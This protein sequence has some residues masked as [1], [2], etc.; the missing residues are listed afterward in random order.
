[1]AG[2][3]LESLL[4]PPPSNHE[5]VVEIAP[6]REDGVKRRTTAL[7]SHIPVG[8]EE[9]RD[10][11]LKA[12]VFPSEK[13][14]FERMAEVVF[15]MSMSDLLRDYLMREYSKAKAEGKL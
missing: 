12:A 7:C 15:G 8:P 10:A 5:A 1:M 4:A 2:L 13:P 9:I 6:P 3:T 11:H 14:E